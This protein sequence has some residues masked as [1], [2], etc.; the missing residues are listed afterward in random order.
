MIV[1]VSGWIVE[2]HGVMMWQ[3]KQGGAVTNCHICMMNGFKLRPV[4]RCCQNPYP[5]VQVW[6]LMGTGA[7]CLGKP[8]GSLW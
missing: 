5:Y 8:Q 2:D 4:T 1:G 6:V 3:E 7:G